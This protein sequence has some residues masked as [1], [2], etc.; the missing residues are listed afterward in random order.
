MFGD[1]PDV[2]DDI[3]YRRIMTNTPEVYDLG[4]VVSRPYDSRGGNYYMNSG[5]WEIQTAAGEL[6]TRKGYE[7]RFTSQR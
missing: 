7:L 6:I 5:V 3:Y 4:T 1:W 2:G